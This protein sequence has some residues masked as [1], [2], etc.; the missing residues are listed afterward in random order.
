MSYLTESIKGTDRKRNQDRILII[1]TDHFALFTL[2]DGVSS[3]KKAKK[4]VEKSV[5]FIKKYGLLTLNNSHP[6]IGRLVFQLNEELISSNLE[7]PFSTCSLLLIPRDASQPHQY[8]NIGDSRIYLVSHQYLSTCDSYLPPVGNSLSTYLGKPDLKP[9]DFAVTRV[10]PTWD[11][12]IICSDGF[13]RLMERRKRR[14]FEIFQFRYLKNIR[15]A[16]KKE[17]SGNNTD[18]ATYIFV[19]TSDVYN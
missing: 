14:F 6:D 17:I 13:Y 1:T 12:Y 8:L 9:D 3:A 7:E 15:K 2:F 16:L 10:P 4:G 11:N 19:R 5:R 18:D